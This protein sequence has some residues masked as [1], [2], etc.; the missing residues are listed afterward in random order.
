MRW[1]FYDDP[2]EGG[3]VAVYPY[4]DRRA[5]VEEDGRG[6]ATYV[7]HH[8]TMGDWVRALHAAGLELINLVEPEWPPDN[9]GV[10]GGWSPLRGRIFPGTAI[11]IAIRPVGS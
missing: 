8:R 6:T 11:F 9:D 5:Y 4:F 7:E 2:G 10:W 1:C 3:L